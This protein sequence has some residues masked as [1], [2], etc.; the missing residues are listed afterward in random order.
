MG[1]VS[2]VEPKGRIS[3][4]DAPLETPSEPPISCL[5][6]CMFRRGVTLVFT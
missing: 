6:L 2:Y 5:I 1:S 4:R 3:I